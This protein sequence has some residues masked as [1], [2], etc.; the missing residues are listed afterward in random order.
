MQQRGTSGTLRGLCGGRGRGNGVEINGGGG[1]RVENMFN[2]DNL[3]LVLKFTGV[4]IILPVLKITSADV[5]EK[6]CTLYN[7]ENKE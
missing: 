7:F 6:L 2:G 4:D 1:N 5:H 3:E